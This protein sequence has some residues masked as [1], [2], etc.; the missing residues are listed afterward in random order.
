[1]GVHEDLTGKRYGNLTV[2]SRAENRKGRVCWNCVCDCG[3]AVISPASNLKNGIKTHCG[4]KSKG[5]IAGKRFGK[6]I[7]L[8]KVGKDKH[9]AIIWKCKCDCGNYKEVAYNQLKRGKIKSCGC[10][11]HVGRYIHGL[12][13]TRIRSVHKGMM[14]RCFCKTDDNYKNYGARGITVCDEWTGEKGLEN[15][16]EWAIKNGYSDNLTLDRKDNNKGYSPDNCRWADK[17]TQQ[18]NR[19]NNIVLNYMDKSLTLKQ[20]C[21]ELGVNYSSALKRY[22]RGLSVE[23]VLK[24]K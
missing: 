23:E 12:Y 4:C 22:H 13:G 18:N 17:V 16:Y 8:C 15:F 3:N 24:I 2:V 10:S 9:G 21:R 7:A 20:W 11:S 19:R 1:M 5:N 14:R 6:L